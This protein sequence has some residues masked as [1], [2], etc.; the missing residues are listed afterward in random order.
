MQV[1]YELRAIILLYTILLS[2]KKSCPMFE[3]ALKS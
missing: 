3:T 2:A 1:R